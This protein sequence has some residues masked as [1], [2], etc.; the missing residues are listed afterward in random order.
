MNSSS[1]LSSSSSKSSSSIS[2]SSSVMRSSSSVSSRKT[3]KIEIHLPIVDD[4]FYLTVNGLRHRI[5]YWNQPTAMGEWRDVSEWFISGNN[6]VQFQAVNYGGLRAIKFEMRVDGEIISSVNCPSTECLDSTDSGTFLQK[7]I[8]TPD[9][10]RPSSSAVTINSQVS[11]KL[12]INDEYVSLSTPITLTLPKGTYKIG[13]GVSNDNPLDMTDD[14]YEYI[15][16]LGTP[17]Q[18]DLKGSF[19]EQ[20]IVVQEG[21]PTSVFIDTNLMPLAPQNT[22]KIAILPFQSVMSDDMSS[23]LILTQAMLDGF[24]E[25]VR[26]TGERLAMPTMYGLSKWDVT[27]LPMDNILNVHASTTSTLVDTLYSVSWR[28]EYQH[29]YDTY[30]VVVIYQSSYHADGVVEPVFAGGMTASGRL[31]HVTSG[32]TWTLPNNAVNRGFYHEMYHHYESWEAYN[33]H[34]YNGI[35]GLHGQREHGFTGGG[36]SVQEYYRLFARGQAGEDAAAKIGMDWPVPLANG[37]PFPVGVFHAVRYGRLAP[38]Q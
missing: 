1:I 24:A 18:F 14:F 3:S 28:P 32:W 9:L 13:L 25:Q 2:S 21:T 29:L 36:A 37:Q 35:G 17:S 30:D 4:W 6:V 8:T 38:P 22:V 7:T 23:P 5:G 19:Y 11:G 34:Y 12:Y 16:A 20:Q 31:I 26:V 33:H 10:V 15:L 27:V